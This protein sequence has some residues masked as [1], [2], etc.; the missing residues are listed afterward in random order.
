MSST[1][2]NE[3]D[4]STAST[5]KGWLGAGRAARRAHRHAVTHQAASVLL[6]YPGE[7]FFQ[8]LPLV[9]RAVAELPGGPVRAALL[10]FCE[11]A[12]STPEPE[13]C[14]HHVDVFDLH[15]HRSLRMASCSGRSEGSA[16]PWED[17]E[18]LDEIEAVYA[19]AG[20]R[21]S[22]GEPPDHLAEILAF[23]A[24]GDAETGR[25]LLVRLRPVLVTLEEALRSCDTPY[26]LV[27]EAV[28]MTLPPQFRGGGEAA[29]LLPAQAPS[30]EDAVSERY[31]AGVTPSGTDG[32]APGGR[33]EA[34]QAD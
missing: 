34:E 20:W 26:A 29:P 9:A 14:R 2:A 19:E 13:L 8:C 12:S 22:D 18:L 21:V 6:G 27:V 33:G 17:A 30:P 24:Y 1:T 32:A 3:S 31:G 16:G 4:N 25:D 15:R 5:G 11:H 23:A 7:R 28:G 10:E